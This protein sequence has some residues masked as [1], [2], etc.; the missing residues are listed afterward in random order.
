MKVALIV[1]F[2]DQNVIG[3]DNKLLWHLPADLQ[4]FKNT[5]MGKPIVMGRKTYDSIGRPLPGRP[6][7]VI[8]RN[9]Q[10]QAENVTVVNNVAS[11]IDAAKE[12]ALLGDVEEVMVIGGA[13]IYKETLP[14]AQRIYLTRVHAQFEGDAVFPDFN[15]DEWNEVKRTDHQADSVNPYDFSFITLER[16]CT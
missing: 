10:W 3:G 6:N 7:V 1:A 4:Y 13:Q 11:A 5:T 9:Q 2:A 12:L 16:N 14:I 15:K 8:S